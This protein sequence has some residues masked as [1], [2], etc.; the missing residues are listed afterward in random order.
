MLGVGL[1]LVFSVLYVLS[2]GSVSMHN[3]FYCHSEDPI[4]PQTQ[5]FAQET[6]YEK[7]RGR[8][9]DP[10]VSSCTP[11]KFWLIGRTGAR[12]PP[13]DELGPILEH[14]ETLH[15]NILRNYDSGRTSLCA[16]DIAL[17][18]DWKFDPNMTFDN[19]QYLT[20]AGWNEVQ[21]I[22]ERYQSVFPTLLPSNYSLSHYFF[23]SLGQ[24]GTISSIAAF[25]DGLFGYNGHQQ[26][27]FEEIDNPDYLLSPAPSCALFSNI[28]AGLIEQN[29]FKEGP[30]Y[31]EVMVQVSRKLG[32][33]ASHT[34]SAD[35][36][37]TL[38]SICR[39]EHAWD[40]NSTSALCAAFSVANHQVLEYSNDLNMFYRYGYGLYSNYRRLYE[41]LPCHILQDMLH[42]LRSND[43]SDHRARIFNAQLGIVL[44][45]ANSFD[46]FRDETPI[47]RH[48]F[49]QQ[50]FRQFR[51]SNISPNAQNLAV[52]KY[53]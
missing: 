22:A 35:Q 30:E 16:S 24:R 21:G 13:N 49:A 6:P 50:I 36:V 37:R 23:R 15:G 5:M 34:L 47:T 41:N 40:L 32:F 33:H 48:N 10:S 17:I 42:F 11:S 18:R 1:I 19:E 7:V 44:L 14:S 3:P 28:T 8:A 46:A 12:S 45:I 27:V 38:L 9:I 53:E 29:A 4:R 20:V 2:N 25:A 51:L 31:Q 43:I 26:V 52:I 39:F